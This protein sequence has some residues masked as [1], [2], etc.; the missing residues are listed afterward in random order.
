[1]YTTSIGDTRLLQHL[2]ANWVNHAWRRQ[3]Y[4]VLLDATCIVTFNDID[5]GKNIL[6]GDE[7]EKQLIHSW[8]LT[9]SGTVYNIYTRL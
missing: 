2:N 4:P 7:L 3:T 1:M 6:G 9:K 5:E 8:V